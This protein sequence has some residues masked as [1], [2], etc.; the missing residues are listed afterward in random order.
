M[1]E[2]SERSTL[3]GWYNAKNPFLDAHMCGVVQ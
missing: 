3:D 2:G 1:M